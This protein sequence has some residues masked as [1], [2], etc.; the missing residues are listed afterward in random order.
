MGELIFVLY[1]I[2]LIRKVAFVE[3]KKIYI[4]WCLGE[5]LAT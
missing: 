1:S 5:R 2:N 3:K 4:Q